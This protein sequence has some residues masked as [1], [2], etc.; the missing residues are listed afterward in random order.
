MISKAEVEHIAEL[1]DIGISL[2][3]LEEFTHQF[4][5][6]LEYFDLLDQVPSP[7]HPSLS[8]CNIWREDEPGPSLSQAEV[9]ANTPHAEDGFIRAPR[10]I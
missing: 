1:G 3:E 9:L 6:I 4:N 5:D 2:E 7:D 8:E 10:V